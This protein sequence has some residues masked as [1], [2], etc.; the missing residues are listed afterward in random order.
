MR[1]A[2]YARFSSDLQNERS[3]EDQLAA[4]RAVVRARGWREVAAFADR[5]ISGAALANR[6]GILTL[7]SEANRGGF[8]VVLT[9]ALDRISRD[10]EGTAHVFKRLS[11]NNIRL[12]TL[13]EGQVSELHV[14]LSGTMNQLFLIEL[15]KKTRRGLVAR[16]KAGYS[17]GG[18]CYGYDIVERG[19][20][21][22][23]EAEAS[24]VRRIFKD[25]AR[26]ISPKTIAHAL[27][28]EGV[29]GP[30]GGTWSPT[31]I[32]G[33]RRAQD[34]ILQQELYVGVRVFNRRRFRKHPDTGRRSSI[35]N[36]PS[37]W[38]REPVPELRILSD[39]EWNAV[40]TRQADLADKPAYQARRPKRFLSGLMWCSVCGC[41]M[42]LNGGK[43]ACSGNRE[44][45]ACSNGKIIAA[46]KI[47][48]RVIDGLRRRLLAPEAIAQAVHAYR[49]AAEA[50]RLEI[51]ANRAPIEREL[52]ELDRR[53]ARIADAYVDGAIDLAELKLK[54]PVLKAR[55]A[56]LES[57]LAAAGDPTI[58]ALHPG[59]AERYRQLA[60]DL[61]LVLKEE[62]AEEIR[63][64]VRKLIERIDF[65]PLEGLG[66]YELQIHG[67][68]AA[69]LGV[70]ERAAASPECGVLV[71][72]G[73]GF[74]PVTFRL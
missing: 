37:E 59:A 47:E 67:K 23:N 8:D 13:S 2:L 1:V 42:T 46:E 29:S 33:D 39:E 16:V 32:Y 27:N 54:V 34:G 68:L 10:Q 30:R 60:A 48:A 61:H 21:R 35:L 65:L 22:I 73:T 70:A 17:G 44:R 49:E 6:P 56:E 3:A 38:L 25:Y 51:V 71:G 41:S 74:E 72:A 40:R 14:G 28:C 50:E 12:E 19:I 20:L 45:G 63:A 58:V 24:V 53:I 69:L 11:Y 52:A 55:K 18:R 26:G 36:P 64:E 5:A 66:K 7:L 31:T 9:E 15:G 62:D 43:Y 57:Q 4:L